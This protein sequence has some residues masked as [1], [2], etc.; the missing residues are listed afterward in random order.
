MRL[1]CCLM[2]EG[3][4]HL[5]QLSHKLYGCDALGLLPNHFSGLVKVPRKR[6][7]F[8]VLSADMA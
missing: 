3:R 1:V 2:M 4:L 7:F 6:H 8:C 5:A